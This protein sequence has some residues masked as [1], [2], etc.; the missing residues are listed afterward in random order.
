LETG[1]RICDAGDTG[2]GVFRLS[3]DGQ[4]T[5]DGQDMFFAWGSSIFVFEERR[6]PD[7]GSTASK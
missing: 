4:D 2:S 7:N 1:R 6:G 5:E 3:E